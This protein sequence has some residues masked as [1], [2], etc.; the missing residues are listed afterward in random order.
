M[1]RRGRGEGTIR[2]REGEGRWEAS[3][4]L[5]IQRKSFY[6]KTRREVTEK[7]RAA[8]RDYEQSQ[9]VGDDRQTV[10]QYLA[11]WLEMK[12]PSLKSSTMEAYESYVRNHLVPVIGKVKLSA[13]TAQ[14]VQRV[15]TVCQD[16]GLSGRSANEVYGVLH[17]ALRSAERL[18]LVARN[19]SERVDRPRGRSREMRPLSADEANRLLEVAAGHWLEP[20]L[21]LALSTGMRRGELLALRWREV[22]LEARRLAVVATMTWRHG[23]PAYTTPKTERA[24]RRVALL[25]EMVEALRRQRLI[26]RRW[27]MQAGAAWQ[28][29]RYDAVFSDELGFP[30]HAGR[31]AQQ[32][33]GLLTAADIATI[34]FHDLR[35]TCATLLLERG[36]H[37]KVVSELLGHS[38]V[39]IT[40]GVY[41]HVL[42]HMQ[43][44]AARAM[45]EILR[46]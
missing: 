8:Q 1:A 4:M 37:V 23:E 44:D 46:W 42:P 35:H 21:R 43:E 26:Q 28:G 11:S 20:L 25:P 16:A 22:D 36:V 41:A 13:L 29:G 24:R 9:F 7:L 15:I 3:V 10:A 33:N 40:L 32:L 38:S 34:R 27:Q 30:L 17:A 5:G 18:G 31:V 19:V 39:S 12:R 45:G 14:H 6:G 2:Y